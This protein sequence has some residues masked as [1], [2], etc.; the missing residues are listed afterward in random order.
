MSRTQ[1]LVLGTV[2]PNG[3]ELAHRHSDLVVETYE[4][5]DRNEILRR[6]TDAQLLVA[7]GARIDRTV[8]DAAA[9]LRII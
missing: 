4:G 5:H 9:Q 3:Y 6:T 7:R 1:P 2:R 8:T